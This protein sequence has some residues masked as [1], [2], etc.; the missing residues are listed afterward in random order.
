LRRNC[1]LKEYG[2]TGKVPYLDKWDE[3]D[4]GHTL[5]E[6]LIGMIEIGGTRRNTDIFRIGFAMDSREG[7]SKFFKGVT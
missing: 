3:M 4:K 6:W 2:Y 1:K 7:P 5:D